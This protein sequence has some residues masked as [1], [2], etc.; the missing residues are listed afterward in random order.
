MQVGWAKDYP[1]DPKFFTESRKSLSDPY[2]LKWWGSTS[3][4]AHNDYM[5]GR[6]SSTWYFKIN[7]N[8]KTTVAVST[9]GWTGQYAYALGETWLSGDHCPGTVSNPVTIGSCQYKNSSYAWG[10]AYLYPYNTNATN[11]ANNVN[12]NGDSLFEIWDKR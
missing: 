11:F 6:D 1:N 12:S 5:V 3:A 4:G 10:T 7:G 9:L 8:V 2:D